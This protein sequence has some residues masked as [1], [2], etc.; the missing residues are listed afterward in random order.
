[1]ITEN[2]LSNY[3]I[4]DPENDK[5]IEMNF[6]MKVNQIN[7]PMSFIYYDKQT[8]EVEKGKEEYDIKLKILEYNNEQLVLSNNEQELKNI[9]LEK[10]DYS[11]NDFICKMLSKK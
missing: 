6:E 4:E 11:E 5:N 10:C 3:G 1:M 9:L 2:I 8:I 7:T